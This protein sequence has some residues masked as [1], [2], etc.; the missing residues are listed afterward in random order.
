MVGVIFVAGLVA[1]GRTR[2][3]AADR[4]PL[5]VL[6]GG[7]VPAGIAS[8]MPFAADCDVEDSFAPILRFANESIVFN[9]ALVTPTEFQEGV[10]RYRNL[11]P[12][13][14]AGRG[15]PA[16]L[17]AVLAA[18]STPISRI[19]PYLQKLDA[20]TIEIALIRHRP[21]TTRTLGTFDRYENCHK[22]F[23][24]TWQEQAQPISRFGSWSDVSAAVNA[25][26][27]SIEL[28]PK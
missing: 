25:S 24:L 5:P 16:T 26:S 20:G 9:G 11:F 3:L 14:H 28:A 8:R 2:G 10:A 7:T 18:P 6:R 19:V 17:V 23:H 4:N 21:F 1:F 12:T 22:S 13:L 15:A 27:S